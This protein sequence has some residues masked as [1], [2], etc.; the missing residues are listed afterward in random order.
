M[1]NSKHTVLTVMRDGKGKIFSHVRKT[2][3][4]ETPE[5][6]VRQE[7]IRIP[8]SDAPSPERQLL[9]DILELTTN[10]KDLVLL[11]HK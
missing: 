2:W 11:C 8:F 5:E 1:T 6:R 9:E 4:H 10:D 7:Q 3:L